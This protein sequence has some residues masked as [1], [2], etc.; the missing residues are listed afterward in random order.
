MYVT[1]TFVRR[2]DR[3]DEPRSRKQQPPGLSR[4]ARRRLLPPSFRD[5]VALPRVHRRANDY[6]CDEAAQR[7]PWR[8]ALLL[9]LVRER[10]SH[11][12]AALDGRPFRP[13]DHLPIVRAVAPPPK[14]QEVGMNVR[15]MLMFSLLSALTIVSDDATLV[16]DGSDPVLLAERRSFSSNSHCCDANPPTTMTFC[17]MYDSPD[18]QL[19]LPA[20]AIPGD[21]R[22]G[23]HTLF[24]PNESSYHDFDASNSAGFSALAA[25]LTNGID[26]ILWNC[27]V[28]VDASGNITTPTSCNG[29]FE[30]LTLDGSNRE[31]DLAGSTIGFVRLLVNKVKVGVNPVGFGHTENVAEWDVVWQ[32]WSGVAQASGGGQRSDVDDFLIYA[33]PLQEH[34]TTAA[35][36]TSFPV[37][38]FYGTTITATTFTATLNGQPFNGFNPVAGTRESV[39]V[40][41]APGR[42]ELVLSVDGTRNDG[43]TATDRDRLVLIVP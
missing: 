12:R 38:V 16:A 3:G 34:T 24:P 26:D 39:A 41:L 35:G 2:A 37:T 21:T 20:N 15:R 4:F 5:P 32:F 7:R 9:V 6:R 17:L 14:P 28:S 31:V 8:L 22:V 36:S 43:R 11:L 29:G 40:P 33:N 1:T 42:N 23:C 18:L 19:G 10:R 30:S 13:S 27:D 25:A